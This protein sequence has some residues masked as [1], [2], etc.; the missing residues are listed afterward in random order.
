MTETYERPAYMKREYGDVA[1]WLLERGDDAKYAVGSLIECAGEKGL[2]L[3]PDAEGFVKG[4]ISTD[5]GIKTASSIYSSQY[6]EG[7]SKTK[8]SE[9]AGFYGPLFKGL[10]DDE[11]KTLERIL[12]A[13]ELTVE[14]MNKKLKVAS[15]ILS[16]PDNLFTDE[17]KENAQK[18]IQKYK[19]VA[20]LMKTLEEYRREKL[21]PDAVDATRVEDLKGLVKKLK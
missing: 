15:Y 21:R 3:G 10:S 2:N 18:E 16:D 8:L 5:E 6:K 11:R 20:N 4:T 17:Q 14:E 12:N 9:L 1:A 19:G 13:G 7:F